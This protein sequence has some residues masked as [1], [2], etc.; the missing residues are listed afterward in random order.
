MQMDNGEHAI[1]LNHLDE[2]DAIRSKGCIFRIPDMIKMQNEQAYKPYRFSF[3]PWY[4]GKTQLMSTAREFKE[5]FIDGLIFRF[6]NPAAKFKEL[7]EVIKGAHSKAKEYY[8]GEDVYDLE[9]DQDILE[10]VKDAD[11]E[12]FEKILLL[13]GCFI[14]ELF[15]KFAGEVARHEDERVLFSKGMIH[16]LYHDLFLLENQIPW[17]VLELLFDKTRVSESE[18]TLIGLAI[19]FFGSALSRDQHHEM[20]AD[21]LVSSGSRIVHL[22]DLARR[23]LGYSSESGVDVLQLQCRNTI[24]SATRLKEAGVK[25]KK[26]K[27]SRKILDVRFNKDEGVLEIPYLLINPSTETIFRNLISFEQCSSCITRVTCYAML[28]DCLVDNSDDVD[29]MSRVGIFDN[30]LNPEEA[31]NFLSRMRNG[32]STDVF[33]Y[34]QLCE[35]VNAYCLRWWPKWR[36]SLIH[37]YFTKPWAIVSVIFAI[38]VLLFTIMQVFYK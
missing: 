23:Y 7:E 14:I 8:E 18:N 29:L 32:T 6:P 19:R 10:G 17:F 26:V 37:N 4:Y 12:K 34:A 28:L 24:P 30:W 5:A 33:F 1:D 21:Q 35:D 2:E 16:V 20:L 9:G 27:S 25:F 11:K 36:A 22:I 31:A 38:I 13:D 15:R 3:G